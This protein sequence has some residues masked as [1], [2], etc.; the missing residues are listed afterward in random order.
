MK[1]SNIVSFLGEQRITDRRDKQISAL[2]PIILLSP[3]C[4]RSTNRI[5]LR[6]LVGFW[7]FFHEQFKLLQKYNIIKIKLAWRLSEVL[8]PHPQKG[9]KKGGTLNCVLDSLSVPSQLW[10]H[11]NKQL[12]GNLIYHTITRLC[13]LFF[14]SVELEDNC[15][16]THHYLFNVPLIFLGT[17]SEKSLIQVFHILLYTVTMNILVTRAWNSLQ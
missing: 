12:K 6:D 11:A 7:H 1:W 5:C 4:E 10:L 2:L 13:S 8:L 14:F 3:C 17:S 15:H 16:E 9:G